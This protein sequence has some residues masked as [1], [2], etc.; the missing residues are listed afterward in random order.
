M[1]MSDKIVEMLKLQR[2]LDDRILDGREYPLYEMRL[3]LNV[4]LGEMMN[5]MPT[6]F[7]HWKKTAVDSRDKALVEAVDCVHFWLSLWLSMDGKRVS[8][9]KYARLAKELSDL[10]VSAQETHSGLSVQKHAINTFSSPMSNL[11]LLICSLGF[12]F[13]EIYEGYLAK[14][15]VNHER[16]D[17]NY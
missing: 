1:E 16:Q 15:K 11:P 10:F 7:K 4:E 17:N 3:A 8:E 12:G 2:G 5:E 9:R 6:V 13:D 14:N